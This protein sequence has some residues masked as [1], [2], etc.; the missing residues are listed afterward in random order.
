MISTAP[1]TRRYSNALRTGFPLCYPSSRKF[2]VPSQN[3]IS[4]TMKIDVNTF[5][6][7]PIFGILVKPQV[8]TLKDLT[9]SRMEL[10]L[11]RKN[12]TGVIG[13]IVLMGW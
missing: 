8:K 2:V 5:G 1:T 3:F 6:P 12:K 10:L 11:A 13:M 7:S 9:A 4:R